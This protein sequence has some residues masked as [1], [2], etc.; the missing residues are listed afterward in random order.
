MK[1]VLDADGRRA[2]DHQADGP[3]RGDGEYIGATLIEAAAPPSAGRRAGGDLRA[4]PATSTTRTATRSWS[5]AACEIDVAPDRRRRLGRGRQPRR[6]RQGPGDRVPLLTPADARSPV[7]RRHPARARWPTSA[8]CWP[9][10][11][12]RPPG[13]VAVAVGAGSGRP[14]LRELLAPALPRAP[15]CSRSPAAPSTPPSSSADAMQG[16]AYDAVVGIGGGQTIDAPSTPPPASACRW[17]RSPPTSPT[18]AS[19]RRSPPSTTTRGAARTACPSRSPWSSTRPPSPPYL[20]ALSTR[21][22]TTWRRRSGSPRASAA[23]PSSADLDVLRVG[24]PAQGPDRCRRHLVQVEV[25]GHH[26]QSALVDAG[27]RQQVLDDP[28]HPVDLLA[29]ALEHARGRRGRARPRAGSRRAPSAS[30]QA[31]CAAR[32]RRRP[33]DGACPPRPAPRG[34]ASLFKRRREAAELVGR[35]RAR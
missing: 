29:R 31:A 18:T 19:A 22:D 21:L 35:A 4:R 27:E 10:S 1:V 8:R 13:R 14:D 20:I 17:S 12:S 7:C 34:R 11:G 6:P 24:D 9:T 3:G 26:L 2:A 16:A 33:P 30:P 5:T 28:G 15:T 25:T 32:A 23:S